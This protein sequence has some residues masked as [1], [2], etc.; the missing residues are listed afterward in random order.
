MKLA[1]LHI[2]RRL[3]LR[4]LF[5]IAMAGSAATAYSDELSDLKNEKELA[6]L[7]QAIAEADA[8]TAK[9]KLGAIDTTDLP[10]G[11]GESTD[12]KIEGT[13]LAYRAIENIAD[14]ISNA[15]KIALAGSQVKKVVIYGEK[16][17]N[18]VMQARALGREAEVLRRTIAALTGGD[19]IQAHL[20][21]LLSDNGGCA[22]PLVG[23]KAFSLEPINAALQVLALF[24]VDRKIVGQDVTPD[25]FA[26]SMAVLEKL[27]SGQDAVEA[28]VYSPTYLPG[29][30]ASGP[31]DIFTKSTSL[32]NVEKLMSDQQGLQS[33]LAQIAERRDQLN[34]K[35]EGKPTA[36]CKKTYNSDLATLQRLEKNAKA[37]DAKALRLMDTVTAV[38]DKTG[39]SAIQ[40]LAFADA[41]ATDFDKAYVLQ[42]KAVA[43]GGA[44]LTKT[45]LFTT[46]F[47]FSGGAIVSYLLFDGSNGV[48]KSSRTIPYYAGF[49]PADDLEARKQ[50]QTDSPKPSGQ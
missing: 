47:Y 13:I 2:A 41:L 44:T 12:Q 39:A 35:L 30:L 29:V 17:L 32:S 26:L 40:Q 28:A 42:L 25:D 46:K 6:E 4:Q 48:V 34:K 45:N 8:A 14:E 36:L 33:L 11:K 43:A 9:A 23:T 27:R 3:G 16:Q 22:Q 38:D 5:V 31:E 50:P 21:K 18:A 7:K 15:T 1:Y 49:V 37:V 20:P 24:K 10:K 19:P